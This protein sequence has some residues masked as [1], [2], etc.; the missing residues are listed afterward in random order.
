MRKL[1]FVLTTLLLLLLVYVRLTVRSINAFWTDELAQIDNLI[2]LKHLIFEYLPVIPGGLPGHYLLTL[3]INLLFPRNKYMLGLP[4]LLS[5]IIVFLFIPTIIARLNIID[6]KKIPLVSLIARIGFVFDP[7]YSFQAMEVRPYSLLPMLWMISVLLV[8]E[9][10]NFNDS[11]LER[12]QLFIRITFYTIVVTIVNLWHYYGFLMIASIYLFFMANKGL[13]FNRKF[14]FCRAFY[15][16]VLSLILSLPVWIYFSAG[17]YQFNFD[18]FEMLPSAIMQIYAIDKGAIK[19]IVW[20][21]YFYLSFLVFIILISVAAFITF[22]KRGLPTAAKRYILDA[23]KF[24]II[25][26][27]CPILMI[28]LLD[29]HN[30]YWFLLRQFAWTILPFYIS[31]GIIAC[32]FRF[33]PKRLK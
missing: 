33:S 13:I 27:A 11:K 31:I 26:V 5:H 16:I 18:T 21:N 14:L 19:G 3:P 4:G 7:T 29:L 2:T 15:I 9:M 10:I 6:Q 12:S 1:Y 28:L 32:G 30:R 8:S 20:Q 25:L 23:I 22:L 24:D 17:S